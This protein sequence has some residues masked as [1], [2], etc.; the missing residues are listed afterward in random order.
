[1]MAAWRPVKLVVT[2]VGALAASAGCEA[3]SDDDA[4][5]DTNASMSDPTVLGL[6]CDD[7]ALIQPC[8]CWTVGA[9]VPGEAE[10][11]TL[12]DRCSAACNPEYL[13][14]TCG[15]VAE[16]FTAVLNEFRRERGLSD[17]TVTAAG[18]EVGSDLQRHCVLA[19]PELGD[20]HPWTDLSCPFTGEASAPSEDAGR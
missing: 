8:D 1:M 10:Q 17:Q 14:G 5:S 20:E 13:E 7:P 3:G 19:L 15:V 11:C 2:L 18:C 9:I 12:V 4:A 16:H 6:R